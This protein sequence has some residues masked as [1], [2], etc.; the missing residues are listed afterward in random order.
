[1]IEVVVLDAAQELAPAQF[2]AL[3]QL[4]S[5]AKRERIGR[6][7]RYRDAQNCLLADV[8]ARLELARLTGLEARRLEFETNQWGKP[9]LCAPPG[10]A[11][12]PPVCFNVSHSGD[13][14]VCATSGT[15]VG[16][17]VEVVASGDLEVVRRFFAADEA[18]YVLA[19]GLPPD[20]VR[21]R[22]AEVWTKKESRLKREGRGLSVPLSSFSVVAADDAGLTYH[23]V[24]PERADA[25]CHVCSDQ[26]VA[27]QVRLASTRMLLL[28]AFGPRALSDSFR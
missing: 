11:A 28:G 15:P 24:C 2:D 4:V 19:D 1:M 21:Q 3:S 12:P 25:C 10:A 9:R 23:R 16:V 20:Q 18:A 7:L 26:V 17:D 5:P 13:L 6:F 14:V 27:P 8:L 22:F